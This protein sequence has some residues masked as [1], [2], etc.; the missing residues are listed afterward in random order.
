MGSTFSK[1]RSGYEFFHPKMDSA[2][3]KAK[4]IIFSNIVFIVLNE[5]IDKRI[6]VCEAEISSETYIKLPNQAKLS[7]FG[8]SWRKS[9]PDELRLIY[10][11]LS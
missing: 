11:L 1:M 3:L 2:P 6:R 8:T 7:I 9:Q 5:E 4:K 10:R